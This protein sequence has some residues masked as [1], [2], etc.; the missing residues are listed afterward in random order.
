M[1]AIPIRRTNFQNMWDRSKQTHWIY[2]HDEM[3]KVMDSKTD[4]YICDIAPM[5][6]TNL[7]KIICF[8]ENVEEIK[9][10]CGE[11]IRE[12]NEWKEKYS[13]IMERIKKDYL[14]NNK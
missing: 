3:W 8:S 14:Y 10:L 4:E 1:G 13:P 5:H 2:S 7:H 9:N 12:L 11:S 6:D